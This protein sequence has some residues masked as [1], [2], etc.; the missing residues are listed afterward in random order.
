MGNKSN[1][2]TTEASYPCYLILGPLIF[3]LPTLLVA[4][5]SF[6]HRPT[7]HQQFGMELT[8]FSPVSFPNIHQCYTVELM[9]GETGGRGGVEF[10]YLTSCTK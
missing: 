8:D 7:V 5:H 6:Y 2:S 10:P 1:H 9:L 3:S 4:L